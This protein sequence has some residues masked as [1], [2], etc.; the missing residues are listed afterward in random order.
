MMYGA[1]YRGRDTV[2]GIIK[3]RSAIEA[4]RHVAKLCRIPQSEGNLRIDT[5]RSILFYDVGERGEVTVAGRI[6]QDA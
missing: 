5:P 3:A 1:S 2:P 4:A 6:K